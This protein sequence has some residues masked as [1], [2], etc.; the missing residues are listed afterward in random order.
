MIS[1]ESGLRMSPKP[2]TKAAVVFAAFI[3]G[4]SRKDLPE[5]TGFDSLTVRN[6]L[7]HLRRYKHLP[8]ATQE[9]KA[10][11]QSEIKGG[12]GLAVRP[13]ARLGWAP[14]EIKIALDMSSCD[15]KFSIKQIMDVLGNSRKLGNLPKLT[16]DELHDIHLDTRVTVE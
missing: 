5:A 16:Q 6:V 11:I 3:R 9:E 4:V 1:L 2:D 10:R 15:N 7:S 14:R 8:A 13:Y 12:V